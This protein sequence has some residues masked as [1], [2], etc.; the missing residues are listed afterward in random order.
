MNDKKNN[1]KNLS[2]NQ[3]VVHQAVKS[4]RVEKLNS[5]L[6][7]E[8]LGFTQLYNETI[9]AIQDPA[10]LGVYCYLAS[11]PDEWVI[12][13][14]QIRSHFGIG[15]DKINSI[16][17]TLLSMGLLSFIRATEKGKFTGVDFYLH[18]RIKNLD[19]KIEERKA[20]TTEVEITPVERPPIYINKDITNKDIKDLL[21]NNG[22]SSKSH[23]TEAFESF[24][25]SS[26]KRGEK[27]KAYSAWKLHKLDNKAQ[28][29]IELLE[30][31][32]KVKHGANE[33]KYQPHISTWINYRPWEEGKALT[34]EEVIAKAHEQL[35]STKDN[36]PVKIKNTNPIK[37]DLER[38]QQYTLSMG[39][40][41]NINVLEI[42]L[43]ALNDKNIPTHDV[44]LEL[45]ADELQKIELYGLNAENCIKK[46][47]MSSWKSFSIDYFVKEEKKQKG[48][49]FDDPL[50]PHNLLGDKL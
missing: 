12:C 42:F 23:Y 35:Q 9:N 10:V 14:K 11:K 13:K 22:E 20:N 37:S 44:N 39:L 7:K 50:A 21:I 40:F 17:K 8:D 27:A 26:I 47:S 31:N 29:M 43:N 33:T 3:S 16:F 36:L 4:R 30:T 32:Y 49:W 2:D 6:Y 38:F 24:W 41:I 25:Q 46:F 19:E 28:E 1:I 15:Q 5:R 34:E 48:D 18:L 45:F